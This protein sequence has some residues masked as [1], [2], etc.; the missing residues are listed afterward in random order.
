[1]PSLGLRMVRFTCWLSQ[2][3]MLVIQSN[4]Y[5]DVAV[6][7]FVDMVN[8]CVRLPVTETTTLHNM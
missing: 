6:K 2:A 5:L 1:M 4:A 3:V 7:V 8:I